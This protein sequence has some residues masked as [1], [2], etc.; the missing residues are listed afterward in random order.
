MGLLSAF[1]II[2]NWLVTNWENKPNK[3]PE[4]LISNT[5]EGNKNVSEEQDLE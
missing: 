5:L 4:L 2:N 1:F 3:I